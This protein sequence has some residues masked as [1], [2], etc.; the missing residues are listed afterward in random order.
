[1]SK[2]DKEKDTKEQKTGYEDLENVTIEIDE[3]SDSKE[4]KK[5]DDTIEIVDENLKKI[6]EYKTLAQRV[7][8]DFDNYRKR[9]VEAT[10]VARN[11]GINDV[12]IDLLPV[13]DNCERGLSVVNEESEKRGLELIYKQIQTLFEKYEVKE[14]ESL[15][16]EFNP[17]Y[18]HAIAQCDDKENVNKVIEVFQ[19][20][21]IRKDKVLR[22]A[23]VKVAQ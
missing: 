22:V 12:L 10:R 4:A 18:H 9:N 1:M 13:L 14:I 5:D 23:L 21:Y 19:K 2:K 15:G 3:D 17:N 6:E 7:Q 8:A 16:K 11:D 20:G